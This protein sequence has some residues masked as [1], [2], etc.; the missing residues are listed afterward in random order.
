MV[1]YVYAAHLAGLEWQ[2]F[3]RQRAV[4]LGQSRSVRDYLLEMDPAFE[5]LRMFTFSEAMLENLKLFLVIGAPVAAVVLTLERIRVR[6]LQSLCAE[7]LPS[8]KA[9]Q[10]QVLLERY[11]RLLSVMFLFIL[12]LVPFHLEMP[13]AHYATAGSGIVCGFAS[14]WLYLAATAELSMVTASSSS[15]VVAWV[16]AQRSVRPVLKFLLI[17]H[18]IVLATVAWKAESLGDDWPALVFGVFETLL[19][20]GYQL[21]Q[22]VFVWDD[23][24]KMRG[25]VAAEQGPK[26]PRDDFG[27]LER[28]L[29]S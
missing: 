6:R 24:M 11:F 17:L 7:S 8:Q 10:A 28:L 21:F 27:Q 18:G 3:G 26:T 22:G 19:I 2:D 13:W 5:H 9:H 25:V 15:D 12:L 4:E 20:L 1:I 23:V 16:A 14:I 29:G